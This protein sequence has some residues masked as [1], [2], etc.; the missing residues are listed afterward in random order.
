MYYYP[1]KIVNFTY[2]SQALV[3]KKNVPISYTFFY[4]HRQVPVILFA[5]LTQHE[6]LNYI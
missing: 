6:L 3:C 5:L 2:F 4:S 1:I